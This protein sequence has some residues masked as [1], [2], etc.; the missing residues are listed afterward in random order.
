MKYSPD[1]DN[2]ALKEV[3]KMVDD[4]NT[5]INAGIAENQRVEMLEKL[6]ERFGEDEK[7]QV[8]IILSFFYLVERI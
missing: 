7:G 3:I 2:S 5:A 8:L 1:E 6:E 4:A